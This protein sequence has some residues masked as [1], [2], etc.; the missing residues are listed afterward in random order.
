VIVH[1]C[2]ARW[3]VEHLVADN[4][5]DAFHVYFPDPWWK[6]RH[7]KRRLFSDTLVAALV[8]CLKP[9]GAVYVVS[10]VERIF[11]EA[12]EKLEGA[13]LRHEPWARNAE[14]PAQSSYER[15]YRRQGRRLFQARFV[16]DSD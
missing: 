16:N 15:K 8:R 6:K 2:D 5:V 1:H 12:T 9:G 7:H 11:A 10:D 3:V 13:G 14:D 4:S